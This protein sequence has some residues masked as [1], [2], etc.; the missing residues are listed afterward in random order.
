MSSRP[1]EEPDSSQSFCIIDEDQI[2][3]YLGEEGH[4]H[5]D[6]GPKISTN[7]W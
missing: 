1:K 3:K 5:S 2:M 4:H 7:P 6:E